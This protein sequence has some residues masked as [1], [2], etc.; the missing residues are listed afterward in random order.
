MDEFAFETHIDE[1]GETMIDVVGD[2]AI[3]V[4]VR[5]ESGERIYLPPEGFDRQRDD[6]SPYQSR[7]SPYQSSGDS[8]YQSSADS[9]SPYQSSGDSPYQR[10][11]APRKMGVSMTAEGLQIRHPEPVT[12][13]ELYRGDD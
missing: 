7:D 8:P 2:R 6:D 4:V 9:D 5:S 13:V 3:A 10:S 1:D 11:T 12:H